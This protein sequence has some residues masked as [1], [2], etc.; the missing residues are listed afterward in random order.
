MFSTSLR[1]VSVNR[2]Y[3]YVSRAKILGAPF[4]LCMFRMLLYNV[5]IGP[6]YGIWG[7]PVGWDA[8]P[9]LPLAVYVQNAAVY[10]G[11]ADGIWGALSD[12]TLLQL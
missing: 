8:A 3:I 6:A 7:A 12:E 11:P 9:A 1:H 2:Q 4:S 5:Y 10:L